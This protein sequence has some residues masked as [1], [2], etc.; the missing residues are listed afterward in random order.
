MSRVRASSPAPFLCTP[1]RPQF[2]RETS[3]I[4][5]FAQWLLPC[6]IYDSG[7]KLDVARRI[8][9]HPADP[10]LD[11]TRLILTFEN[12]SS[13]QLYAPTDPGRQ[14]RTRG[15]SATHTFGAAWGEA[16]GPAESCG[17]RLQGLAL[18]PTELLPPV[19]I[20]VTWRSRPGEGGIP[21]G[22]GGLPGVTW[23]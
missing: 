20:R 10:R 2:E 12:S 19:A 23:L 11:V 8:W 5:P 16:V 7:L 4:P 6:W 14:K 9:R 21:T 1:L 13:Q 22:A 17:Y 18:S 3:S 15:C